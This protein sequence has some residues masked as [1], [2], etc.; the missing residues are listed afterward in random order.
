MERD[1]A[2]TDP[3]DASIPSCDSCRRRKLKCGRQ[4]PS[5]TNC[6]NFQVDCVYNFEK[7]KPGLKIGAVESLSRR[8]E[9]VEA[10]LA[11]R[12]A[13]PTSRERP[14]HRSQIADD[15]HRFS[16]SYH[17]VLSS[18]TR[19][20]HSLTNA[21]NAVQ[22][23]RDEASD[24]LRPP[25]KKRRI[26]S[27]ESASIDPQDE[28]NTISATSPTDQRGSKGVVDTYLSCIQPWLSIIH[29]P[30]FRKQL[31]GQQLSKPAKVVLQAMLVATLPYTELDT[32]CNTTM[33]RHVNEAR[34]SVMST[35]LE[36]T[37][38]EHLQALLILT[39]AE[40]ID[41]NIRRAMSLLGLIT[42]Q[43]EMIEID[44]E[45]SDVK[46]NR[47]A[48]HFSR[49]TSSDWIG[50]EEERRVVWNVQIL[51][52]LCSALVGRGGSRRVP[53]SARRLPACASFWYTNRQMAT[54]FL[55]CYDP[56]D[57]IQMETHGRLPADVPACAESQPDETAWKGSL[58]FF[59][60]TVELMGAVLLHLRRTVVYRDRSDV[61]R[62]L[63]T[64]RDLDEHLMR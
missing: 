44:H 39:Y 28:A 23:Y 43:L 5:C 41:G 9:V 61:S 35:A 29:D 52:R 36:T 22:S 60:E 1:T 21:V 3:S 7:K 46:D 16:G 48:Y 27:D 24:P 42:N 33:P 58:A 13:S 20:L 54:P 19:E 30:S 31:Q 12:D 55:Q 40:I 15:E 45:R 49:T 51:S 57:D 63:K 26:Q 38:I 18:L 62:W 25:H 11:Q 64:F 47:A 8:L 56:L 37:C 32:I 4:Q 34:H 17:A 6:G 50:D 53:L 2:A 10:A 14:N 59:I